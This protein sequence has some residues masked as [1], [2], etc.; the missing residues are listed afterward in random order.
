MPCSAARRLTS[1]E[2]RSRSPDRALPL[3][4]GPPCTGAG[5]GTSAAARPLAPLRGGRHRLRC[6]LLALVR[7]AAL[8]RSAPRLLAARGAA[9]SA[10]SSP[11]VAIGVPIG[12][13]APS[14]T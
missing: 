9:T 8:P 3:P 10:L 12:T 13:V 5:A 6:R 11:I 7:P 1:G 2:A 14:S 4:P